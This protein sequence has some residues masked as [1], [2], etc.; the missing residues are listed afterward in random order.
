MK[1]GFKRGG[2]VIMNENGDRCLNNNGVTLIEVIVV[3]VIM[4]ILTA[5]AVPSVMG[6]IETAKADVCDANRVQLERTYETYL[7]VNN[8]DH[9]DAVFEQH[10]RDYGAEVCQVGGDMSYADGVV[11][12]S[13]HYGGEEQEEE[14]GDVP[15]LR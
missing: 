11:E 14:D 1:I 3:V 12:C 2:I 4:A 7:I 13:V 5:I 15:F 9:S 8:L 6:Y 10:L